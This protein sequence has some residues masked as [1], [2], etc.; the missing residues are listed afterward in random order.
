MPHENKRAA[1]RAD[2]E[3]AARA[4]SFDSAP[5]TD[6]SYSEIKHV[7]QVVAGNPNTPVS[8][9]MRLAEDACE[10][11]RRRVA[12]NPRTPLE[13]LKELARDNSVEVRLSVA[14]NP[15]TPGE[16]LSMLG[17]DLSLD[18]RYGVAENPHMPEDI[19]VE[20]TRDDNPYVRERAVR[21][22]ERLM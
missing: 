13:K 20:L 8:V 15:N 17:C 12:E 4:E 7:R 16:I 2:G 1:G 19:L 9:L 5:R 3:P 10:L 21:T 6:S 22:L 11:V 14:E 18:V